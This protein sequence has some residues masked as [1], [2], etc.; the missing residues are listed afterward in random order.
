MSKTKVTTEQT[1]KDELS[2]GINRRKF[3]GISAAG[4]A[5]ATLGEIG[6]VS[7]AAASDR[8]G[9]GNLPSSTE[10]TAELAPLP[11]A[12]TAL[13]PTITSE[14]LS[15]HYGKHHKGYLTNLNT[16]LA[17]T[18]P[19]VKKI[20]DKL[21]GKSLEEIIV[22]TYAKR[23]P[24]ATAIYRNASQVYNHNFYWK[25]LSPT[26]GNQPTGKIAEL[27]TSNF[28]DYAKFK[29]QLIDAAVAQFGTGW[30]WVVVDKKQNLKI[31]ST[32][33]ADSP[34]I[35]KH[36]TPI[37]TIDVWEHAYYLVYKNARKSHVTDVVDKLLNWEFANQN[38][39]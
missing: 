37:L 12:D 36:L 32:G 20:T 33:D 23:H 7:N 21:Q 6:F 9:K 18:D 25:S 28:G 2:D 29:A 27:I 3:L 39:A 17:S 35:Y 16:L 38:L 11:W 19:Q 1:N 5:I 30:A 24:T 31:I 26:G 8:N 22:A 13:E 15:Y 34:L 10:V 14:T 4:A